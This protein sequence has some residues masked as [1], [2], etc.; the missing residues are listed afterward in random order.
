[1]KFLEC[2]IFGKNPVK[3]ALKSKRK[4]KQ[5][6]VSNTSKNSAEI[7]KLCEEKSVDVKF[8]PFNE[9]KKFAQN[10]QGVVAF[11]EPIKTYS[12]FEILNLAKQKNKNPFILICD[13]IKDPGNLGAIFRTAL[14]V[15]VDGVVVPKKNS[16]KINATVE[17]AS[18]GAVNFLKIAVVS[19]VV[20]TIKVLKK[21][22]VFIYCADAKGKNFYEF[23]FKGAV[24]LVVGSEEKGVSELA[25]KNCD[26]IC[27][28][29]MKN[30]LN[31]LNV[32]VAAAVIMYEI[33]RQ[34]S[35]AKLKTW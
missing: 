28:I 27:K 3:E 15:G 20:Q 4:I 30:S 2:L 19:N 34:N 5:V 17:K 18:A 22:G 26:G 10:T 7:L 6:L 23:N 13:K 32:S 9:I 16:A 29:P 12:I 11:L 1:M 33:L 8:K 25:K 35:N 21:K 24:G 31:S 14:A